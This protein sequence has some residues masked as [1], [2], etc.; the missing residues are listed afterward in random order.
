MAT[1]PTSVVRN[2]E[3]EFN[4]C[5]DDEIDFGSSNDD[6]EETPCPICMENIT[7]INKTTT[8]C[9]HVFHSS[10]MFMN[11]M[12]RTS[13]PM[14]RKDLICKSIP[15]TNTDN[16]RTNRTNTTNATTNN[17]NINI[18]YNL[19]QNN[20]QI[21]DNSIFDVDDDIINAL[22]SQDLLSQDLLDES[23]INDDNQT[24]DA[25]AVDVVD[26]DNSSVEDEDSENTNE[27]T[28]EDTILDSESNSIYED[29]NLERYET[30]LSIS[31]V[32]NKMIELGYTQE[33]M[34]YYMTWRIN[35]YY[36]NMQYINKYTDDFY[37]TMTE[38]MYKIF[39]KEIPIELSIEQEHELL[40]MSIDELN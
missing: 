9:G 30:D 13:C 5:V 17:I 28:E 21:L 34:F 12:L 3:N 14:C 19:S 39:S 35:P 20:S 18:N 22:L 6:S 8:A 32:T 31:Q 7:D 1:S 24:I 33:D 38:T 11:L 29:D 4:L 15:N 25:Y 2:L 36:F 27:S 16:T 10:C 26:R 23:N 37:N 40:P